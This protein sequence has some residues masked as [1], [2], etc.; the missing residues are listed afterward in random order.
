[1]VSDEVNG[2]NLILLAILQKFEMKHNTCGFLSFFIY[3][4]RI[5]EFDQDLQPADDNH[6][7]QVTNLFHSWTLFVS[8]KVHDLYYFSHCN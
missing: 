5:R 1:M 8:P 2:F 4:I 3:S 6:T 7:P